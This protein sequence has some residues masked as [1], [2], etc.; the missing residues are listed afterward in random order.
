MRADSSTSGALG[1]LLRRACDALEEGL[2]AGRACRAEDVLASFPALA[3]DLESALE[4]V[5]TEFA[6]RDRLDQRPA[7]E[8]W[9]ARFPQ[10]RDRLRR[11][12]EVHQGLAQAA[13]ASSRTNAANEARHTLGGVPGGEA[14]PGGRG[15]S[16]GYELLEE[17]GRGGMGVVYR[18][19]Q[20]ALDRL[21]ALKM[22][23]AGPHAGPEERGRFRTEVEAAA[24]LQ[25][26]HIVTVYEVGE[27]DGVPFCAMELVAGGSLA[28]ALE[29]GPMQ[30]RAAAELAETVARAVQHAHDQGVLHRDLNPGNVLL[31]EGGAPKVTDFGL[32]KR[33]DRPAGHTRSGVP[34]GTPCYMA[35]ELARGK[36]REV[37]PWTDVYGLGATLYEALTGRPPFQGDTPVETLAQV[38]YDDAVPPR[39][40][41]PGVPR[42]LEMIC[43][44][45]LHKDP[46][47]RYASARELADD[48][49]RFLD[50][51][52]IRARPVGAGERAVKWARRRPAG[53]A[54][55]AVL[56]LVAVV[57]FPGV[58]WL[59]WR[60]EAALNEADANLY[61]RRL[62]LAR[63]ASL[64]GQLDEAV[65]YL[66]E[67][68]PGRRER[69][70]HRLHRECGGPLLTCSPGAEVMSVAWS[71]DGRYL[72]SADRRKAEKPGADSPAAVK[73]W[74]SA[75][76]REVGSLAFAVPPSQSCALA[77]GPDGGRL[78]AVTSPFQL[79][80]PYHVARVGSRVRVWE[81]NSR[82]E[83][84]NVA[85][86]H[87]PDMTIV[88]P[89]SGGP[90]A[91]VGKNAAAVRE[92]ASKRAVTVIDRPPGIA[93][94]NRA[95]A[96]G[97]G[98]R[99]LVLAVRDDKGQ[100]LEVWD[101]VSGERA[102]SFDGGALAARSSDLAFGADGGRL[103]CLHGENQA[104]RVVKVYDV[105]TGEALATLRAHTGYLGQVAFSADGRLVAAAGSDKTVIVWGVG[106]G[107]PLFTFRGHTQPITGLAFRPDGQRLASGAW[108]GTVRVW[109]VSPLPE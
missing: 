109:D 50:D 53:A 79:M 5:Y 25:H 22:I 31:G 36:G 87:D 91:V 7:P 72:A 17:L 18:A 48:L 29:G 95:V 54:L 84:E 14:A 28:R 37:G 96:L 8:E 26:P 1:P 30:A 33:L 103:A 80:L 58:T 71:P 106:D 67:C 9:Y 38:M 35:P 13:G 46:R 40:L 15:G 97:P 64:T 44:K 86:P 42:D 19:R 20:T 74:G 11:L 82:K 3:A 107:R 101:T 41:R 93:G 100:L 34:V 49:R 47:G 43:L 56:V 27:R 57:G 39:R 16:L 90:V 69:E 75:D 24:R 92:A 73:V 99:L 32:A 102:R 12:F 88:L 6:V 55:L 52:P 83:V 81:V 60:A 63:Y 78:T 77:F 104:N 94:T 2:C 85:L 89:S 98:G 10:L 70:W 59:W 76:G 4:V 21:V 45:C 23:L 51:E 68:P 108:D 62:A 66:D 65:H 61:D 105:T